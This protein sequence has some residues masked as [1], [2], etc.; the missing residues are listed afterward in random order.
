MLEKP[1]EIL[2]ECDIHAY[3]SIINDN[4]KDFS[5]RGFVNKNKEPKLIVTCYLTS[6]I[7][8]YR[9]TK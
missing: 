5:L 1:D 9:S 8:K 2:M 4:N 3:Q 6:K 7:K